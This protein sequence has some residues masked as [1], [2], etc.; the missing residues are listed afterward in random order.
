VFCYTQ[1]FQPAKIAKGEEK[2]I[3]INYKFYIFYN[4]GFPNEI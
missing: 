3:T 4:V 1:K 2:M